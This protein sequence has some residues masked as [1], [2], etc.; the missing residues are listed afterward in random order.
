MKT[1]Q[2]SKAARIRQWLLSGKPLT[3]WECTFR[4]KY[5]DLAGL[6]RD[7]RRARPRHNNRNGL[8]R[9]WHTLRNLPLTKTTNG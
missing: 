6:V 5:L 9:Q 7:M 2:E 1:T 4:F 3:Q 8:C